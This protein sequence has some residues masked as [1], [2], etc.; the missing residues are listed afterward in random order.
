[1]NWSRIAATFYVTTVG[2]WPPLAAWAT[3]SSQRNPGFSGRPHPS[4]R[5]LISHR[6]SLPSRD[7]LR[8]IRRI[9][10]NLELRSRAK[11]VAAGAGLVAVGCL[12]KAK[13][14]P[15]LGWPLITAG[16]TLI[17]GGV[18]PG[19]M[20][21]FDR[22]LTVGITAFLNGVSGFFGYAVADGLDM[23]GPFDSSLL[24]SGA[25][26]SLISLPLSALGT[27]F[28]VKGE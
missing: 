18:T 23:Q 9:P 10:R 5:R 15:A 2:L 27:F 24:F 28:T 11:C 21:S 14:H 4:L 22:Q 6:P 12:A 19:R 17:L 16:G 7:T 25:V 20:S 1:M 8:N 13:A 26:G 3:D